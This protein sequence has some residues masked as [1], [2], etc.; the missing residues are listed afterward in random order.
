M[1]IT[2]AT[3]VKEILDQRPD[4]VDV[5]EKHGVNVPTE[6]DECILETELELCDSMCHIDD[7][8]ALIVDLQKLFDE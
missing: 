8:D 4:A 7:I 6:C 3:T 5:F 1:I 2:T